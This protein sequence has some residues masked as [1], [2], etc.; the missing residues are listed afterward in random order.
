MS[1]ATL[2]IMNLEISVTENM[3][4]SRRDVWAAFCKSVLR[5]RTR[6]RESER[7]CFAKVILHLSTVAPTWPWTPH[8]GEPALTSLQAQG[9]TTAEPLS[10]LLRTCTFD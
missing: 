3:R 1:I 7:T 6:A 2:Q 9:D 4:L 8:N 5:A 10:F